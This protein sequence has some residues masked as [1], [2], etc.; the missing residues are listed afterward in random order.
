MVRFEASVD[1]AGIW[2]TRFHDSTRAAVDDYI[3]VTSEFNQQIIAGEIACRL[4]VAVLWDL[5][6]HT[7]PV[8]QR[9]VVMTLRKPPPTEITHHIAYVAEN[10]V[11]LLEVEA[12]T[13]P[14]PSRHTRRYY[15]CDA[16]KQAIQWL[17][18]ST[19]FTPAH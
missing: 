2:H 3:A 9:M 1:E 14:L 12:I 19:E 11:D 5:T 4:P 17:I 6:I 7:L 16:R 10:H 15:L 8:L 18:D 13:M